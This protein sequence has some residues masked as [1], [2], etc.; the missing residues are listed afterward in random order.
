MFIGDIL[1]SLQGT[2][3]TVR[4]VSMDKDYHVDCYHCEVC[5]FIEMGHLI[6]SVMLSSGR[7]IASR[8]LAVDES[9]SYKYLKL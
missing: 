1:C 3:E 4:V 7:V 2:E 6:L 5:M 8:L 9:I